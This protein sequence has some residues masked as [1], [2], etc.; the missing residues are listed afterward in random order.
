MVA[1][2]RRLFISSR[3]VVVVKIIYTLA[4]VARWRQRHRRR[5]T[6]ERRRLYCF[7]CVALS[8][9][10]SRGSRGGVALMAD[11]KPAMDRACDFLRHSAQVVCSIFPMSDRAVLV[12]IGNA[13]RLAVC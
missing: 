3:P 4:R 10:A 9:I 2:P 11:R 1:G 12:K 8:L 5:G 6:Q 13:E 7:S